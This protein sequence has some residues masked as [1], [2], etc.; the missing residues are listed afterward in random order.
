MATI[1]STL[2]PPLIDT[3]MPAFLWEGPAPVTFSLSP[4]NSI[5]RIKRIHV[6]LVNQ[7]TNQS[8]FENNSKAEWALAVPFA[9]IEPSLFIV[10][11]TPFISVVFPVDNCNEYGLVS[12]FLIFGSYIFWYIQLLYITYLPVW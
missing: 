8:A 5:S 9:V 3:F 11:V 2:Y 12:R 7:K 10:Q 1:V 4:Y 6:S